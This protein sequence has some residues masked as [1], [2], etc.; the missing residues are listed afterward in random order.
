MLP[1]ASWQPPG[2]QG[3][4]GGLRELIVVHLGTILPPCWHSCSVI[5]GAVL[6]S[7]V[8]LRG[9]TKQQL[10]KHKQQRK[11]Q[12]QPKQRSENSSSNRRNSSESSSSVAGSGA[13]APV[14]SGHRA[15]HKQLAVVSAAFR[16]SYEFISSSS[17]NSLNPPSKRSL[18]SPNPSHRASR[19]R[20]GAQ[21]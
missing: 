1:E 12:K 5:W 8:G 20:P 17:L 18:D 7:V 15:S 9:E 2:A 3:V 16:P 6:G 19:W 11:Q 13:H 14:R 4:P 10:T 21:I